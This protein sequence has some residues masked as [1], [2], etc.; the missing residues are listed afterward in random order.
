MN[1]SILDNLL[2]IV[3]YPAGIGPILLPSLVGVLLLWR[4]S[5]RIDAGLP[6]GVPRP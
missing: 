5:A 3:F 4:C 2:R 1:M 6:L